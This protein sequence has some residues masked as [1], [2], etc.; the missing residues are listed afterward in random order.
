MVYLNQ[1]LSCRSPHARTFGRLVHTQIELG[2]RNVVEVRRVRIELCVGLDKRNTFR[3]FNPKHRR[4]IHKLLN[5]RHQHLRRVKAKF[6][7]VVKQREQNG[8]ACFLPHL[9]RNARLTR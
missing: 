2:R 9:G 7:E 3:P 1:K 8:D 4:L 6:A 5:H